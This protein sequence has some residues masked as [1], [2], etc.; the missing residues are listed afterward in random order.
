MCARGDSCQHFNVYV[1]D[2]SKIV[3]R[4]N[5]DQDVLYLNKHSVGLDEVERQSCD[6]L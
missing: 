3:K 6:P 4:R 2:W 5:Q 1:D